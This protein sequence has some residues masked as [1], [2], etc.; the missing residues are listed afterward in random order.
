MTISASSV[1]ERCLVDAYRA[2]ASLNVTCLE[3]RPGNEGTALATRLAQ[4]GLDAR[5]AV[6]AA[7]AWLVR[8]CDLALLGADTLAPVGLVHKVGTLCLALGAH[9]AGVPVVVVAGSEK[10]LPGLV[11]GWELDGGPAS[12]VLGETAPSK[13]LAW[14][15]YFDLTPLDLLQG[16]VD[17]HGIRTPSEVTGRLARTSIHEWIA[18]LLEP[19]DARP[20]EA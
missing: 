13:L 2:G 20:A 11:R 10:A 19:P 17:E 18:D 9:A 8:E 4:A 3:S 5:L 7:G 1:V 15:G 6:D 12:E 16:I 14:N